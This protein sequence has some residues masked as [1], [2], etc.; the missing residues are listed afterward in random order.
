M[1]I[2]LNKYQNLFSQF[3]RYGGVGALNF[4]LS[5][6]L[7]WLLMEQVKTNYLLAHFL[8]WVFGMLFTFMASFLWVFKYSARIQFRSEFTKFLCVY[9]G[10]YIINFFVLKYLV[11]SYKVHPFYTQLCLIPFIM[12]F[13]FS[14]MRFWSFAGTMNQPKV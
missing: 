8:T 14:G 7:Y 6:V 1:M 2:I 5:L 11:D 3:L 9:G 4:L 10:T 13:N 12:F